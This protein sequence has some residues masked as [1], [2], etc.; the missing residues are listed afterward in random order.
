M[1]NN[2]ICEYECYNQYS[3]YPVFCD[4]CKYY[5]VCSNCMIEYA[6]KKK[7][8]IDKQEKAREISN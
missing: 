2:F 7:S 1:C 8:N 3:I 5:S 4:D 6:C